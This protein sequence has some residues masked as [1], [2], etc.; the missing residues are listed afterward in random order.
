MWE[1]TRSCFEHDD[2]SLPEIGL[3]KLTSKQVETIVG[4]IR[5]KSGSPTGKPTLI[6]N[7]EGQSPTASSL[8]EMVEAVREGYAVNVCFCLTDLTH[9]RVRL[10]EIMV[11]VWRDSVTLEY[12]QGPGWT[13]DSVEALFSLLR[14]LH[15]MSPQAQLECECE[16][17][18]PEALLAGWT[19]YLKY[20]PLVQT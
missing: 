20:H 18:D 3:G 7:D 6:L 9:E 5:S 14:S 8:D 4:E 15:A 19:H 17:T 1:I 16:V 13:R 12:R 11:C 10:P 2:G